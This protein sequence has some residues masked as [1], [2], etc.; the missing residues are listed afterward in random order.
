MTS[1]SFFARTD[2]LEEVETFSKP[3]TADVTA[4]DR[5]KLSGILGHYRGMAHP[6]TACKKDQIK[7]GLS[8]E[9]ANRRCAVIKSLIEGT[10]SGKSKEEAT[11][12]VAEAL[13]VVR[14]SAG[15]LGGRSM[16]ALLR[17]AARPRRKERLQIRE[18]AGT[19]TEADAAEAMWVEELAMAVALVEAAPSWMLPVAARRPGFKPLKP[20]KKKGSSSNSEF[21]RMHPRGSGATGGQFIRK[22]SSGREVTAVQR[23]LG[24]SETGTYGGKTKRRVERFQKNHGLQVDGVVGAQT[25]AA[26]RGNTSAAPGALSKNDRRYLR[27]YTRRTSASGGTPSSSSGGGPRSTAIKTAHPASTNSGGGSSGRI[28][29]RKHGGGGFRGGVV[30]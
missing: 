27:R 1:P 6:F 7:H 15:V 4:G 17:E 29:R 30:V 25:V 28:V 23:R 2:S 19:L 18:A 13:G 10:T 8:E 16:S 24:I 3:G 12:I 20:E 21:N 11:D 9:H 14:L 26:L 5:K 22:G